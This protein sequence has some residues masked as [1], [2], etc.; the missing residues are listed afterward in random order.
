MVTWYLGHE[1]PDYGAKELTAL[2]DAVG[3]DACGAKKL[4][5]RRK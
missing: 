4:G 5:R 2:S 3:K 1:V